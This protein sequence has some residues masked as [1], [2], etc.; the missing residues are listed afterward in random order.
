MLKECF[1][2]EPVLG[3]MSMTVHQAMLSEC[4][5]AALTVQGALLVHHLATRVESW[6]VDVQ[7]VVS[8]C[9]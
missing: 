6:R 1:Q 8:L 4:H 3:E 7:H 5:G 9:Q 2:S